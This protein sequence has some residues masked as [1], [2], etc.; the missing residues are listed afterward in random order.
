MDTLTN[1]L[2]ELLSS[3]NLVIIGLGNILRGDDGIGI[4]IAKKLRKLLK[5]LSNV[6]VIVCES[7]LENATHLLMRYKP[8]HMLIIDAVYVDGG[9]PGDLYVFDA[10]ELNSYTS[11][12]THHLPL[13]LTLDYLITHLNVDV[14]VIGIQIKS[15]G[16]G[17]SVSEEVLASGKYLLNLFKEVVHHQL[18][19]GDPPR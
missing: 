9:I 1:V 2:K 6:K 10:G 4:L 5:G 11:I 3:D 12:T 19:K 13:K 18:M 15:V 16:L 8:R 7:G 14:K 17:S